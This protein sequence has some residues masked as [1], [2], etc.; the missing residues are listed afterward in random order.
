[1]E[2]NLKSYCDTLKN[3][4]ELQAFSWNRYNSELFDIIYIVLRYSHASLL[5]NYV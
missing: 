3:I 4:R 2:C 1:V 5:T